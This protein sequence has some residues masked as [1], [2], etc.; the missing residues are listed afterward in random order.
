MPVTRSAKALLSHQERTASEPRETGM[1][2]AVVAK[3][4]HVNDRIR[5]FRFDIKDK[6]GFNV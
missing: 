5:R 2:A 6:S 1:H 3:I 4:T